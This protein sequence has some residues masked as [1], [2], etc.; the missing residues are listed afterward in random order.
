M[1]KTPTGVKRSRES[2]LAKPA[3][4]VSSALTPQ[5]HRRTGAAAPGD[6]TTGP[7]RCREMPPRWIPDTGHIARPAADKALCDAAA[8]LLAPDRPLRDQRPWR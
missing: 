6:A 7:S 3:Q 8:F 5:T 4:S 2:S 1:L